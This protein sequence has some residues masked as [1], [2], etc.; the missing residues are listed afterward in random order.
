MVIK[1]PLV[2]VYDV[3][4]WRD[5]ASVCIRTK[6]PGTTLLTQR[7][8]TSLTGFCVVIDTRDVHVSAW[9]SRV[10]ACLWLCLL[11][12]GACILYRAYQQSRWMVSA[13]PM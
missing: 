9:G 10:Q 1:G 13:M 4:V 6:F 8:E 3:P 12:V 5:E 7:S 11:A 2:F